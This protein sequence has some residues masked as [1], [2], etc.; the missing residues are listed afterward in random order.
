MLTSDRNK[1][2]IM[3]FTLEYFNVYGMEN[4]EIFYNDIQ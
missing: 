3:N 4:L 1:Y 2:I